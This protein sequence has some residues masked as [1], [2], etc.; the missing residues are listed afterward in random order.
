[1]KT[2]LR[3]LLV[4]FLGLSAHGVA[5]AY[6]CVCQL[7]D[8][9][10][11]INEHAAIDSS[12][13]AAVVSVMQTYLPQINDGIAK[14]F[15][16]NEQAMAHRY[17]MNDNL[18]HAM[19]E[20]MQEQAAA[21]S[22]GTAGRGVMMG[23]HP[24]ACSNAEQSQR[25][26]VSLGTSAAGTKAMRQVAKESFKRVSNPK[27]EIAAINALP[28]R[29]RVAEMTGNDAG[30]M[31][32]QQYVDALKYKEVISPT[33][34]RKPESLPEASKGKP[35]ARQYE[36]EYKKYAALTDLYDKMYV[37]DL[38]MGFRSIEVNDNPNLKNLRQIWSDITSGVAVPS[39]LQASSGDASSFPDQWGG[40]V[41]V[42]V[43]GKDYISERDYIRT[44]VFMR[45]A[46]PRYQ[47]SPDYGLQSMGT[48]E[49]LMKELIKEFAL[50]NRM[51]Y[52]IMNTEVHSKM[53]MAIEGQREADAY[54][55][56]MLLQLETDAMR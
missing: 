2:M 41:P 21:E 49:Q 33:P 32:D 19:H 38:Q 56:P 13:H 52:E 20:S 34:P 4:L 5:K 30:T 11:A 14:L 1:M 26:G 39:D 25:V 43:G 40:I 24:A 29:Q 45:Y 6:S 18:I 37:R 51:L 22:D 10:I 53:A 42:R 23:V 46:N 31:N 9:V 36:S 15:S 12:G 27:S 54:Y 44:G 7:P 28:E 17:G 3:N 48:M 35:Q 16:A 8:V 55:K 50:Q 47:S